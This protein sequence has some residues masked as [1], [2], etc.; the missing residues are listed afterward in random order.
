M[1]HSVRRNR[2]GTSRRCF[3]VFLHAPR[4]SSRNRQPR[5]F[6]LFRE[7]VSGLFKWIL[8]PPRVFLLLFLLLFGTASSLS[9]PWFLPSS[10]P[11]HPSRCFSL[12]CFTISTE[13]MHVYTLVE[14]RQRGVVIF[15]SASPVLEQRMPSVWF[16]FDATIAFSIF[17]VALTRFFPS[18]PSSSRS[19]LGYERRHGK[20]SSSFCFGFRSHIQFL[21]SFF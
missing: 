21:R 20:S 16:L 12:F 6:F 3:Q 17:T 15:S 13:S 19:G 14:Q 4:Y 18:L 11:S 7:Q 8:T 5:R 9:L 10:R 2:V 1:Q